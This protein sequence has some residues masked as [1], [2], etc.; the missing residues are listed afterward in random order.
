M[1][2]IDGQ[3]IACVTQFVYWVHA[4]FAPCFAQP[5]QKKKQKKQRQSEKKTE[6]T[7]I[8]I[9]DKK[10]RAMNPCVCARTKCIIVTQLQFYFILLLFFLM[11]FFPSFCFKLLLSLVCAFFLSL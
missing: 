7:R 11:D 3:P 1:G 2:K 10:S 5:V 6:C 4:L 9:I 8:K